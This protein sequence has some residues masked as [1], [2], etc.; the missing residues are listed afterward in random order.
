MVVAEIIGVAL[1]LGF[2]I[3]I[4][5]VVVMIVRKCTFCTGTRT[6]MHSTDPTRNPGIKFYRV[7]VL[8]PERSRGTCSAFKYAVLRDP[9]GRLYLGER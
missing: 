6:R 3:F 2:I 9:E 7:Q 4:W 1:F 5:A 8:P